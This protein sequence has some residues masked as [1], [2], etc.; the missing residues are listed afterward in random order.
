MIFMKIHPK[1][2]LLLF[3]LI[4]TLSACQ[5]DKIACPEIPGTPRYITTP[6][7]PASTP[8]EFTDSAPTPINL[9]GKIV[10]VDRVVEGSLCNDSWSGTVYV[11]CNVQVFEWEE[12]PTFL[13]DCD[14]NIAPDTIVYVAYHNNTA[15]YNGC[16]CHTGEILNP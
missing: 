3:L 8:S 11:T 13:K 10:E 14:L 5:P 1:F 2:I 15:Y 4:F 6:P 12:Q 9:D 16:S 7:I